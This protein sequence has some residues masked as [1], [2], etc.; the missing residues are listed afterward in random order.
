MRIN[1]RQFGDISQPGSLA[2]IGELIHKSIAN[3]MVHKYALLINGTLPVFTATM[4]QNK[5]LSDQRDRDELQAVFNFVHANFPYVRDPK[6]VDQFKAAYVSLALCEEGA[7]GGD[8]DDHAIL[9]ASLLGQLGFSVG[10]QAWGE[11]ESEGLKHV[12]AIAGWPKLA[13]VMYVP[14]DTTVD[15]RMGWRPPPGFYKTVEID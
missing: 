15:R 11:R 6:S 5:R 8:C 14:L 7:C 13:P 3:P 2:K 1:A 12:Y 4:R 10:A 9:V